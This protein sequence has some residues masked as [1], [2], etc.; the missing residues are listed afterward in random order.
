MQTAA[1]D[2]P[3]HAWD[4]LPMR[5]PMRFVGGHSLGLCPIIAF[6]SHEDRVP[7][8]WPQPHWLAGGVGIRPD[9]NIARIGQRDYGL[10]AGWPRLRQALRAANLCYGAAIDVLTAE[11]C[12]ELIGQIAK[13]V[14]AGKAEWIAHGISIN[15]PLFDDMRP[16][17][18]AAY[19]QETKDRLTAQNI[20]SQGWFGPE[21]SE[22]RRTPELLARAGFAYT[23]DWCNDEQP[24]AMTVPAGTLTA[25]PQMADLDDAFAFAAPRG[26]TPQSYGERIAQA[27]QGL[28]KDGRTSAR[29]MVWTMRPFLSG[30]PFR[31]GAIETALHEASAIDGVFSAPPSTILAQLNPETGP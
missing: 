22:S 6:E 25:L 23:L 1:P 2:H 7:D 14:A 24:F 21:Y 4:P 9:P 27:A 17:D 18:E 12:P 31:I 15:R 19:L 26:I 16:Q 3:H 5:P 29:V 28:A 20:T 13:D 10:R 8:N 11:R 30:Q